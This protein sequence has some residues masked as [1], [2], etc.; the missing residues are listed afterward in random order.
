MNVSVTP[1]PMPNFLRSHIKN[2]TGTG[3]YNKLNNKTL[4]QAVQDWLEDPFSAELFWGPME[5]WDVSKVKDMRKLFKDG[6]NGDT[7]NFDEN[8]EL[9]DV[10]NV[11]RMDNMFDTCL[12]FN[13]NLM[14]WKVGNV[15]DMGGMFNNAGEFKADLKDWDVRNCDN[16]QSMF[17]GAGAFN[18]DLSKWDT[19]K[20]RSNENMFNGA[21]SFDIDCTS[22]WKVKP[23][24]LGFH[25]KNK[26][27]RFS[28][29]LG[30]GKGK[31]KGKKGGRG[32]EEGL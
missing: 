21:S 25:D 20:V 9:W 12:H 5:Y 24:F 15:R 10:S 16:M 32:Q 4:V 7:K 17:R 28:D 19:A 14:R 23:T 29:Y 1:S 30:G 27:K 22:N 31:G 2:L 6:V 3:G 11:E 13:S 26:T 18:S 8:L